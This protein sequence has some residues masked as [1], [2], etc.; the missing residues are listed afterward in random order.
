QMWGRLLYDP[1]LEDDYFIQ[2]FQYRYGQKNGEIL[3]E[4]LTCAS[5]MPLSLASFYR[6]TWDFTLYCEG[7]L[8]GKQLYRNYQEASEA[9][10]QIDEMIVHPT[11]DRRYLNID[12]Y[13]DRLLAGDEFKQDEIT[14]QK[15]ADQMARNHDEV[16]RLCQEIVKS[17]ADSVSNFLIEI[18]DV[19]A[20]AYLSLYF[21]EKIQ[22]GIYLDLARKTQ[23]P[24]YQERAIKWLHLAAENWRSLIEVTQQYQPVSLLHIRTYK[25]SWEYFYPKVLKD[26]EIAEAIFDGK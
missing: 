24:A 5:E 20:W 2:F 18:N 8:N 21:A 26:I 13:V 25:F 17:P 22:A 1:S 6:G 23:N 15:L 3:F 14:P 10:I 7:F 11:L 12:Q 9:F 19:K 4:A 16:L